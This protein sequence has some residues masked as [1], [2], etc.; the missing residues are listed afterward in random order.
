MRLS[1]YMQRAESSYPSDSRQLTLW[2]CMVAV[3]LEP[4]GL[5]LSMQNRADEPSVACNL[6]A[7]RTPP[8]PGWLLAGRPSALTGVK[9]K[10]KC[11]LSALHPF[12]G[13]HWYS[14]HWLDG[15]HLSG[16]NSR[17]LR[18]VFGDVKYPVKFLFINVHRDS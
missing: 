6:R 10:M 15:S 4:C 5:I 14:G 7:T 2:Q 13:E 16:T 3:L 12:F 17:L 8:V 18:F 11:H 1:F 9:M